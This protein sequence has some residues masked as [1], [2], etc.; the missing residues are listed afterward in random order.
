[1]SDHSIICADNGS[2]AQLLGVAGST[3]TKP[4]QPPDRQRRIQARRD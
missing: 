3:V 4:G 2:I 1:L